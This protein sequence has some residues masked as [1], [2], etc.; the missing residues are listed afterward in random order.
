METLLIPRLVLPYLDR[1]V[2][3]ATIL[4]TRAEAYSDMLEGDFVAEM[5][6]HNPQLVKG[7]SSSLR[8]LVIASFRAP[9][10]QFV[11]TLLRRL[12]P[13][14]QMLRASAFCRYHDYIFALLC[15]LNVNMGALDFSQKEGEQTDDTYATQLLGQLAM[16]YATMDEA[17]QARVCKRV[18]YSGALPVARD[19]ASYAAMISVLDGGT[20]SQLK[21]IERGSTN[22]SST[23][24][25]DG[26]GDEDDIYDSRAEAKKASEERMKHLRQV[27][28]ERGRNLGPPPGDDAAD[29]AQP[30]QSAFQIAVS[31][32]H[33]ADSKEAKGSAGR[34]VKASFDAAGSKSEVSEANKFRLLGDLP[35]LGGAANKEKQKDQ[36]ALSLALHSGIENGGKAHNFM[37]NAGSK[38]SNGQASAAG[39]KS[40]AG[41]DI[42]KEFLCAINGHVMKDPVKVSSSGIVFER[43][44]IE[45]WLQT[46]GAVCPITNGHLDRDMLE[47][48]DDL[49]NRIKRYHI[50][51]TAMRTAASGDDDLYDF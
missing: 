39:A 23:T 19:T 28:E 21:Y 30:K 50:Q 49:R 51:Q 34:D 29:G 42:P 14:A 8:T 1:C 10:S 44:T 6:L 48:E 32:A 17:K 3:H 38:G 43:S 16:I 2:M 5:A 45:L 22:F 18:M 26:G 40:E 4:N 7:I 36:I 20:G 47:P 15:L 46:R 41:D 9:A 24:R 31:V 33:A 12:N 13:T 27:D 25:T 35:S 37:K 11:M